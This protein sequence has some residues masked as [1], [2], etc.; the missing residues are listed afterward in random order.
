[1]KGSKGMQL[2]AMLTAVL[3]V[4][5][6]FVPLV[7]AQGAS[8]DKDKKILDTIQL[9]PEAGSEVILDSFEVILGLTAQ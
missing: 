5:M 8:K 4:S 2:G 1:M 6:A 3:I 7:S 9:Q